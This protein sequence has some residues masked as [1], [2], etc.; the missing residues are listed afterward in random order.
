MHLFEATPTSVTRATLCGNYQTT[1]R[2]ENY[3][4]PLDPAWTKALRDFIVALLFDFLL[5]QTPSATGPSPRWS[6]VQEAYICMNMLSDARP[7]HESSRLRIA[8]C[9]AIFSR[10]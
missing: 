4:K 3:D 5:T 9:A 2:L 10:A 6:T 7:C 8:L 1:G